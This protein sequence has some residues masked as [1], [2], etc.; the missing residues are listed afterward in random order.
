[1]HRLP[2]AQGQAVQRQKVA[3]DW[4]P[5]FTLIRVSRVQLCSLFGRRQRQALDTMKTEKI[6]GCIVNTYTPDEIAL[7]K[8]V[9]IVLHLAM[10]WHTQW[11]RNTYGP[12]AGK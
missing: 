4:L 10:P 12:R 11:P 1:M 8:L 2:Q 6:N 7:I 9:W 3:S 5:A